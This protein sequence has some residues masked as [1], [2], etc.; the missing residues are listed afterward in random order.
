MMVRLLLKVSSLMF[1]AGAV[2]LLTPHVNCCKSGSTREHE[3]AL[4]TQC[5]RW[6]LAGAKRSYTGVL[7]SMVNGNYLSGPGDP[8]SATAG[9]ARRCTLRAPEPA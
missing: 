7:A 9:W 1:D 4:C 8:R 2:P 6:K 3:P 5:H